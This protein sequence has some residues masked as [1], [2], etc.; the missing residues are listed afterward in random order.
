MDSLVDGNILS[1]D[2]LS[3]LDS[4]GIGETELR[5]I[6]IS[7][8]TISAFQSGNFSAEQL[9]EFSRN[10]GL[11]AQALEALGLGQTALTSVANGSLSAN[12]LLQSAGELGLDPGVLSNMGISSQPLED[13]ASIEDP[14]EAADA[15][16]GLAE[17][18]SGAPASSINVPVEAGSALSEV[19]QNQDA[20]T[21]SSVATIGETC[22]QQSTLL[23][24]QAAPNYFGDDVAEI[25]MALSQ[26]DR[27]LYE[28]AIADG[29]ALAA[30][31]QSHI[32]ARS[33]V[34]KNQ[35]TDAL[36]VIEGY[37]QEIEDATTYEEDLAVNKAIR[38]QL[39]MAQAEVTSLYTYFASAKG[40]DKV[41]QTIF[42]PVPTFPHDSQWQEVVSSSAKARSTEIYSAGEETSKAAEELTN[43]TSQAT[44]VQNGYDLLVRSKELDERIPSLQEYI[45][46][47]ETMKEHLL[48]LEG[49][50]KDA[51]AEIYHDGDTAAQ[52]I[53][54]DLQAVSGPYVNSAKWSNSNEH[55]TELDDAFTAYPSDY[56]NRIT[57]WP[58]GGDPRAPKPAPD[59]PYSYPIVDRDT[60]DN[61]YAI[62]APTRTSS[63]YE[64]PVPPLA[65]LFQYYMEAYRREAYF[66]DKR[67]GVSPDTMTIQVWS[68][69]NNFAPECLIG[70]L[71]WSTENIEERPELFDLSPYCTHLTYMDGDVE[72]Y[73]RS[74]DLGGTDAVLWRTKVE[75]DRIELETGGQKAIVQR[76][77]SLLDQVEQTNLTDTV[78]STGMTGWI[79]D[80]ED[81]IRNLETIA[82]ASTFEETL[83]GN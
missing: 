57:Y 67:R 53:L 72:D 34:L 46:E 19:A 7:P 3:L 15:A 1:S 28:E 29:M 49:L 32:L 54:A 27:Y 73:I 6:G 70:P 81:D 33:I 39:T 30:T 77:Q 35:M 50:I 68:E 12:S 4:Q 41:K 11:G 45:M 31:N 51:S 20:S 52:K 10:L 60:T 58:G 22:T 36:D 23:T 2:V 78:A 66:G 61:P 37:A 55:A 25:D 5:A 18:A 21:N 17:T 71:P 80:L 40:A 26:G 24:N 62:I 75:M 16:E 74:D 13:L 82:A 47:H 65:G 38:L 8:D 9:I 83:S 64:I 14:S 69:L 42:K 76:A 44:M 43:F 79:S 59:M 48:Y 63:D 56:G